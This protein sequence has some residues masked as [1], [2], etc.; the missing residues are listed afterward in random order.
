MSA[1]RHPPL[2]ARQRAALAWLQP[3]PTR[4]VWRWQTAVRHAGWVLVAAAWLAALVVAF[5]GPGG[6]VW[7]WVLI[8]GAACLWV[9]ETVEVIQGAEGDGRGPAVR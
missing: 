2:P 8:P 7:L 1:L 9:T 5:G 3:L 6:F 4:R